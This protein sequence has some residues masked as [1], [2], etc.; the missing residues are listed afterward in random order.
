MRTFNQIYDI[1]ADRKGGA[2]ALEVLI[3]DGPKSAEVLANT[4]DDRWLSVMTKC[5]FQAGFN[6]KVVEAMWPSF[7]EAFEGFEIGHCLMLMDEDFERLVSDTRIVRYGAKIRAVQQ[8][9]GFIASLADQGGIGRVIGDWPSDDF[10]GL[11]EL[12]KKKATR[13]GG[14]TGQYCLRFQGRDGFIL[15]RDVIGRLI[16]E[17]VIDKAPSS[18]KAMG[19]VQGAFN[20]WMEQSGCSLTEIS[21]VVAMSL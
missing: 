3:G 6:W 2:D 21:R 18:K 16:A 13:M 7:E 14:N 17:G 9:A 8:N 20:T 5:V 10:I 15:S 12:L 19:Q 11:L 4:P 1:A